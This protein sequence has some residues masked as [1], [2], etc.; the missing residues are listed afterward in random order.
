[1]LPDLTPVEWLTV[2]GFCLALGGFLLRLFIS[3]QSAK[4][5]LAVAV[6]LLIVIVLG[7]SMFYSARLAHETKEMSSRIIEIL[8]NSEKTL[9]QVQI[10]MNNPDRKIFARA[11]ALL[12]SEDRLDNC[13]E[14]VHLTRQQTVQVRL[15]RVKTPRQ[16]R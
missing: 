16:N 1:M 12:D 3:D 4:M 14:E 5:H 2:A 6:L 13:L 7:I 8:G 9:D 10:E 11:V 15:W